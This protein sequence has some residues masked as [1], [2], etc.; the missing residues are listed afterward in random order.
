M[1]PILTLL[2]AAAAALA[3]GAAQA[4]PYGYSYE[5]DPYYRGSPYGAPAYG[6]YDSGYYDAPVVVQRR[7]R[8]GPPVGYGGRPYGSYYDGPQVGGMPAGSRRQPQIDPAERSYTFSN[9]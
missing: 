8:R 1:R 9:R 6:G 4:Q 5:V 2:A 7:S 3:A